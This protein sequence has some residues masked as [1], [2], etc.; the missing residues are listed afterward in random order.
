MA[1]HHK[2]LKNIGL[3][4]SF[5]FLLD[6]TLKLKKDK[7]HKKKR[8]GLSRFVSGCHSY[9]GILTLSLRLFVSVIRMGDTVAK[10]VKISHG[11]N[12]RIFKSRTV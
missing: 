8:T 2:P 5:C 1:C 12:L 3:R 9:T 11:K 10:H 6:K 7:C 4:R